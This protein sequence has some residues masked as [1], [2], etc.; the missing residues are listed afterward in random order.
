MLTTALE[1][2]EQN[3]FSHFWQF[4]ALALCTGCVSKL[5]GLFWDKF[6]DNSREFRG[7]ILGRLA[8]YRKKILP[9]CQ[10]LEQLEQNSFSHF[11]QLTALALCTGCLFKLVA[12]AQIWHIVLQPGFGHHAR[13]ESKATSE[14]WK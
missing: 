14:K 11:G 8:F 3:S 4:I 2:L 6:W 1:Q 7:S 10:P 5:V 13:F 9:G 12:L